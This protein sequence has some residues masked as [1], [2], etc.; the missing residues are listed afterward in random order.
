MLHF[1]KTRNAFGVFFQN[2]KGSFPGQ[3]VA[4]KGGEKI[5]KHSS[6]GKRGERRAAHHEEGVRRA[7]GVGGE[8]FRVADDGHGVAE[9]VERLH[10]VDVHAHALFPEQ[11]C[12]LRV[13]PPA[14][15][16]GYVEGHHAHLRKFFKRLIDGGAFLLS[17]VQWLSFLCG[18]R[19]FSSDPG[20]GP[21]VF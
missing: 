21:F 4:A 14:F 19:A 1:K 5:G 8:L 10:R 11:P 6:Y 9:V 13:A 18:G 16:A 12:E 2:K 17:F 20:G 15:V 7:E 3:S